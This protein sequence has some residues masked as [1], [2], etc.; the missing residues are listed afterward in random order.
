MKKNM[1]RYQRYG[2][3]E[4][5]A[6]E[7]YRASNEHYADLLR[8]AEEYRRAQA[9]TNSNPS[10]G[11]QAHAAGRPLTRLLNWTQAFWAVLTSFI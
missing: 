11:Q 6:Q 10:T 9:L 8:E 2:I 3:P 4:G 7:F 5:E 1:S